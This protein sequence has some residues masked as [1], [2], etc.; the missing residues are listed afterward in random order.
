METLPHE[1]VELILERLPVE[2]LL[3]CKTVSKQWRSTIQSRYFKER[4]L[5]R[6][7]Q[8]GDPPSILMVCK[9]P[10]D[11][12]CRSLYRETRSLVLGSSASV[13]IPSP[14]EETPHLVSN[15]SCDGLVCVYHPCKSGFVY[16][17][18]TR[19]HRPLPFCEL[20]NHIFGLGKKWWTK[21]GF[22]F[23]FLGFGKDKFTGTYKPVC[24]Y[25]SEEIGRE[26]ATTCEVFDI[27]TNSWRYVTP[28]APYR[29]SGG[30]S[31]VFV[32]GSLH[33]VTECVEPKVLFFD[34]HNESFQVIKAPFT[35]ALRREMV[36]CNLDNRLCVSVM[37]LPDQVIWSFNSSDK[38][39]EQMYSIDLDLTCRLH[40]IPT[41]LASATPC[42]LMPL[43]LLHGQKNKKKKLLFYDR[44]CTRK[45]VVHD[46]E[47][48]SYDVVFSD[49]DLGIPV[50][51]FQSLFSI[52]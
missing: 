45:L 17:P 49:E 24:L 27:C 46:P 16:N 35:N 12:T 32:D 38:T 4:Q 19:W 15:S 33:W 52:F 43:A 23:F 8:S 29:I 26:N 13:K 41:K 31:P 42:A 40:D 7:Q 2:S 20:Q 11:A 6:R 28:A 14:W 5:L 25:N 51:Y 36:L 34:L 44:V 3:R 30:H 39:W 9:R 37:K 18:I 48:K 47:T 22:H 10:F 50:C 21:L 1:V